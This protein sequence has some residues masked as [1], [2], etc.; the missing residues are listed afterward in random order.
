M[1][2]ILDKSTVTYTATVSHTEYQGFGTPSG[3]IAD[4]KAALRSQGVT[5]ISYTSSGG[6]LASVTGGSFSVTLQIHIENGLGFADETALRGVVDDAIEAQGLGVSVVSSDILKIQGPDGSNTKTSVNDGAAKDGCIAGTGN[7][8]AGNF[9]LSC[10]FG[11]L[12]GK[13]LSTVGLLTVV[14]VLGVGLFVLS[15][16]SSVAAVPAALARRVRRAVQ[17]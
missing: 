4:V 16:A 2:E 1:A 5:V 7:D 3:L 9:S 17:K 8:L 10:W 11:N 15:G 14:A 6:F 12:T 13:G